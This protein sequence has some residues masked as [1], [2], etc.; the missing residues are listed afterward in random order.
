MINLKKTT[1]ATH[2]PRLSWLDTRKEKPSI[3]KEMLVK[4]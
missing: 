2:R 1:K 4:K 3:S